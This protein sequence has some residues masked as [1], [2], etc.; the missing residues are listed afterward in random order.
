MF[1]KLGE[2]L[3]IEGFSIDYDSLEEKFAAKQAVKKDEGEKKKG[4]TTFSCLDPKI[5]QNLVPL[6][7]PLILL[8]VLYLLIHSPLI[9][10]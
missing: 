6:S 2:E 8:C 5:A 3:S 1:E 4:P 7:L 9:V 10:P